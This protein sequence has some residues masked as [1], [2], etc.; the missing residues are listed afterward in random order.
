M[1]PLANA[2][3]VS[4]P[5][6]NAPL[7]SAPLANAPLVPAVAMNISKAKWN[8]FKQVLYILIFAGGQVFGGCPR[9]MV[10]RRHHDK[11]FMEYCKSQLDERDFYD[12]E[13]RR[14]ICHE[15]YNL[16]F[17]DLTVH[18]ESAAGR[19]LVP[20]DIDCFFRNEGMKEQAM[21]NLNCLGKMRRREGPGGGYLLEKHPELKDHLQQESYNIKLSMPKATKWF[22][23]S[24][25]GNDFVKEMADITI[26]IDVLTYIGPPLVFLS[27]SQLYSPPFG[28]SPDFNVN[29]LSMVYSPVP[30]TVFQFVLT[31]PHRYCSDTKAVQ[32]IQDAIVQKKA[33][34]CG[35]ICDT[36]RILKMVKKGYTLRFTPPFGR[37]VKEDED[38]DAVQCVLC[39][40][41]ITRESAY[42]PHSVCKAKYHLACFAECCLQLPEEQ[43]KKCQYCRATTLHHGDHSKFW[44]QIRV[45]KGALEGA[46]PPNPGGAA[47]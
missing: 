46:L 47:P 4:A 44:E 6:A 16:N 7:V 29:Q 18:P 28:Q 19:N 31:Q 41:P 13:E 30:C 38:Q 36:F 34:A 17:N 39:L 40:A 23:R 12:E 25:L 15:F 37:L 27:A 14:G 1:E 20:A 43:R 2:P 33:V 35:E 21:D 22:L 11:L 26:K 3:L 42:E 10:Y 8:H 9:D 45:Y 5:L 24:V 32:E